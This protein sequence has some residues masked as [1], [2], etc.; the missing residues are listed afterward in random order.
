MINKLILT[1][2]VGLVLSVGAPGGVMP[3][4]PLWEKYVSEGN[5]FKCTLPKDWRKVASLGQS[6]SEKK[7]YG[8]DVIGPAAAVGI[9]PSI[10]VK[11]YARGNT[12][13]RSSDEFI[14]IHTRPIPG[15]GLDGDKYGPVTAITIAGRAAVKFERRK[16]DFAGPRRAENTKIPIY[17]RYIVLQVKEGFYVLNYYC[18]FSEAKALS[19][20]FYGV[21]NSFEPL[22]K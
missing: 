14:K 20:A 11:Y 17:E 10:S 4:P 15:L 13:F 3:A 2:G 21:T 19:P 22:G 16:S 9:S 7:I 6:S 8:V 12:L 5:Y 1:A 18:V